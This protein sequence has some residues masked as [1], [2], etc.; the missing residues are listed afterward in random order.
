M[1][2][3]IE[4]NTRKMYEAMGGGVMF[5]KILPIIERIRQTDQF[6]DF[7]VIA[8]DIFH[9]EIKLAREPSVRFVARKKIIKRLLRNNRRGIEKLKIFL[10]GL[11][12]PGR[13]RICNYHEP[14]LVLGVNLRNHRRVNNIFLALDRGIL[15]RLRRAKAS[16][17]RYENLQ[18]K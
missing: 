13:S 10:C 5:E 12:T 4:S 2:L 3:L 9:F 7:L 6:L 11:I 14:A 1:H 15:Y 18:E 8:Q 17:K 16:C